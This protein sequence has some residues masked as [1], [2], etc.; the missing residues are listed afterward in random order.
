MMTVVT[1]TRLHTG[2]EAEWDA[3][4]RARFDS[5]GEHAGWIS[6]ADP[7]LGR[8]PVH[9]VIVGTLAEPRGL[10]GVALRPCF[11]G[12]AVDSR[13]AG[14]GSRV[15]RSGCGGGRRTAL[16]ALTSGP[17]S[18][19]HQSVCHGPV[20]TYRHRVPSGLCRRPGDDRRTAAEPPDG[21]CRRRV[22]RGPTAPIGV[23]PSTADR[24]R[25]GGRLPARTRQ[26]TRKRPWKKGR[27]PT[28]ASPLTPA[29]RRNAGPSHPGRPRGR[30]GVVLS[31]LPARPSRSRH[32]AGG[33]PLVAARAQ[34]SRCSPRGSTSTRETGGHAAAAAG[35]AD[36]LA[37]A[38][39]PCCDAPRP[40]PRR[41]PQRVHRRAPR[42]LEAML[43]SDSPAICSTGSASSGR[44]PSTT[45]ASWPTRTPRPGGDRAAGP[46]RTGRHRRAGSGRSAGD[47]AGRP[48]P[49]DRH[50][51][52]EYERLSAEEQRA[53]GQPPSG[54]RRRR[55]RRRLSRRPRRRL[56]ERPA[57]RS[58]TGS[59]PR[60]A[61][62][63]TGTGT[64]ATP[65]PI[66]AAV[67]PL[68]SR[69]HGH[70]ADRRSLRWAA[71]GPDARLLRSHPVRYAAAGIQLPHSSS[72]QSTTGTPGPP[73][74]SS[75]G[76]CVLLQ[77][78]EPCRMYIGNGQM[79]HA[80]TY[81]E[82]V[83]S[84][85]SIRWAASPVP[86]GSPADAAE[87]PPAQGV[88]NPLS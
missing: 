46:R 39:A 32:V 62:A 79:V 6:G 4:M 84:P 83:K 71:A 29:R 57:G 65:A 70:G 49:A 68:R 64:A 12:P 21:E 26:L 38:E 63:G 13:A 80:S 69:E 22:G 42:S 56:R 31:P 27:P 88:M 7:D 81:G 51:P 86:G 55:P 37:A 34:T 41:R 61:D 18:R 75:P 33:C 53:S 59:E 23:K 24:G 77:P 28:M 66:A 20:R 54:T 85:R 3:A 15:A 50:V 10:G 44:S 58:C 72:M 40:G 17:P 11:P 19:D 35:A 8:R 52:A 2:G 60:P 74:R 48:R 1:T 43:S 73:R 30:G 9:R 36:D 78:G 76:P 16:T 87:E 25:R 67:P 47:P 14:G 82:P 45:T 5:A